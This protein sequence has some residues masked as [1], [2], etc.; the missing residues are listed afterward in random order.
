M[1]PKDKNLIKLCSEAGLFHDLGKHCIHKDIL[2]STLSKFEIPIDEKHK[3]E[4]EK[5]RK[6]IETEMNKHPICTKELLD[7]YFFPK[8]YNCNKCEK[9]FP[10][11]CGDHHEKLDGSGYPK[12][13]IKENI[14][15]ITQIITVC[16]IYDAIRSARPYEGSESHNKAMQ[17]LK[18]MANNNKV[19]KNIVL[20][21]EKINIPEIWIYNYKEKLQKEEW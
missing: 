10:T 13:K 5:N 6:K 17:A 2:N 18:S 8:E 15:I 19:N 7:K 3:K 12:N 4:I 14:C 20:K 11:I 9:N 16:D 1:F 21:L